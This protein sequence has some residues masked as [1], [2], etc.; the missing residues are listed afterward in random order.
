MESWSTTASRAWRYYEVQRIGQE[1]TR[2]GDKLTGAMPPKVAALILSYDDIRSL[3][4]QPGAE[5]LTYNEI[6]T[7]Y[8]PALHLCQ[9]SGRYRRPRSGAHSIARHRPHPASC[10]TELG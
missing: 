3:R 7:S 1:I 6:F 8:Y 5:G 4:L 2:L 10:E 9:H